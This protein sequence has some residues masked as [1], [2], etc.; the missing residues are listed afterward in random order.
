M[1]W[2][3]SRNGSWRV[4]FRYKKEQHT[5]WLGEVEEHEARATAAKVDYWLM[6]LK[7]NLV[8]L[9]PGCSI[10]QFVQYDGKPPGDSTPPK[11]E[12]TLERLRDAYFESQEKKLE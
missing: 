3:Q 11:D 2:L 10:V 1:A 4:L 5:F 9:P 6:R 8:H 7:Q 12:L